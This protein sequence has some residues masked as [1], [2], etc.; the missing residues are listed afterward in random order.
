[1]PRMSRPL[2]LQFPG[3][4]VHVSSRGNEKRPTFLDDR[5]RTQ[6]LD[7]LGEAVRRFG[8]ILSAYVLMSNHY[9]LLL[10]LTETTLS[11]GLQWLNG[12]Y[13]QWFNFGHDRVGHLFQGRP[14]TPLVDKQ[15]YFLEVLRYVVLNPVRA[16]MVRH[17]GDY[18]WSSYRATAGLS[19]A[20]SWLAAD[21][22]LA[23]FGSDRGVARARYQAFVEAGIGST[24]SPWNNLVGQMYLGSEEFIETM[25]DH[26]EVKPRS[27]D[28][29]L[30]Q[31]YVARPDMGAIVS[32]VSSVMG[33]SESEVRF[34]RGGTSRR[35][36]AWLGCYEGLLK[37]AEMAAAL[38]LRSDAQI[39][40]LVAQCDHELS[41]DATMR[42][43]VDRCV[44]TLCGETEN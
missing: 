28:H 19:D 8:W 43:Y 10:E 15:A 24:Q 4:L 23:W 11:D 17:P 38:R 16:H 33:V 31:R 14:H 42:D 44:A 3:A 34:G 13:A 2:R 37:N 6:F 21:N 20:P 35:L 1:M 22:A 40:N 29:P 32:A 39:T 27:S 30:S 25:R 9:H 36:A 12:T 18:E 26:V 41:V 5:D 7:L